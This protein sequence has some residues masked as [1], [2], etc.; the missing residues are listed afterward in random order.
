MSQ[1]PGSLDACLEELR[2]CLAEAVSGTFYLACDEYGIATITF[3][4][5]IIES[6]NFQGRRGDFAVELLKGMNSASCTFRGESPR[7]AKESEL[8]KRAIRWLTG[9]DGKPP[10]AAPDAATAAAAL[11][12]Y[13][14]RRAIETTSFAFFGPI[15]AVLCDGAFAGGGDLK[16]IVDQLASN[17]APNEAASFRN[18]VAQAV[19]Q[20]P[21]VDGKGGRRDIARHRQA[22]EK[23]SFA[24]LGPI[25]GVLCKKAFAE[26]G[27]LQ[28]V[29]D[30]L[31]GNLPP[32][33]AGNFRDEIARATRLQ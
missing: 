27:D 21:A 17:L 16:Q 14:Y 29:I 9:G 26:C 28:Q 5:G 15:A 31:A 25:A 2:A 10:R 30:E 24:F 12:V 6:V 22:V 33:E 1:Q 4:Q 11:P 3:S 32:N 20:V 13:A 23:I 7:A 8:S 18:A 19:D